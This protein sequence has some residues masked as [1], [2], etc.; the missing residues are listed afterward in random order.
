MCQVSSGE[1]EGLM[2]LMTNQRGSNEKQEHAY[3]PPLSLNL[4]G[5]V[6]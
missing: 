5:E 3:F 2:T 1:S 4:E 6:R